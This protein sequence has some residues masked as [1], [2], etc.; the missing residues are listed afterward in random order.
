MNNA[1]THRTLF[2]ACFTSALVFIY[3]MGHLIGQLQDWSIIWNPPTVSKLILTVVLPALISFGTGL[4][5]S[6]PKMALGTLFS[7]GDSA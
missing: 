5:L 1:W 6:L 3:Q 4:G 7:K 2:T